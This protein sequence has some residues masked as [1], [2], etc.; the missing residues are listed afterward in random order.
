[1]FRL[2]GFKFIQGQKDLIRKYR[3]YLKA[4]WRLFYFLLKFKPFLKP[5]R[6]NG[7]RIFEK[8]RNNAGVVN[9]LKLKLFQ[10]FA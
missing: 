10:V 3:V 5:G 1:M 7:F 9:D 4:D 6:I 2:N 8:S